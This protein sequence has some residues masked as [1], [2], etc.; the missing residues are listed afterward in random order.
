[1]VNIENRLVTIGEHRLEGIQEAVCML[2]GMIW[3]RERRVRQ[4]NG[5]TKVLKRK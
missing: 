4:E 2:V 1:M 5:R 3:W